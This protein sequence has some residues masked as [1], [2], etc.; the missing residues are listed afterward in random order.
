MTQLG[1]HADLALV[2]A[3]VPRLHVLDLQRPRVCR[4]HQERLEPLV[5]DERVAVHGQ[6]VWV[7]LPH[8]GH[9]QQS[10]FIIIT[11]ALQAARCMLI[12]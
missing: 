11:S 3:T 5:R 4:F 12:V 9:L 1:L 2:L 7:P 6:D 8:P 10:Q